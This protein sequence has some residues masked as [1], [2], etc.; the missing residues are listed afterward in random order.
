MLDAIWNDFLIIAREEVGSRV[1]ETWLKAVTLSSWDQATGT[2]FIEAP[3]VFVKDWIANNYKELFSTHLGRLVHYEQ[4]KIFFFTKTE[5]QPVFNSHVIPACSS[6][7]KNKLIPAKSASVSYNNAKSIQ[8]ASSLQSLKLNPQYTFETC[9]IG[10]HNSLAY[11]AAQ[12]VVDKPGKLYN[13]LYIYG[14]S[15]L[16][17]THLMHAIGNSLQTK[18]PNALIL[19]QTADRFVNEFIN[20]IRCNKFQ[21]FQQKYRQ[22]DV[23]LIDDIQFISQK[24]QTQEAFFHIFNALHE[25]G[26]Q[27]VFSSDVFP[28]MIKGLAERLRS[29]LEWGLVA[30][31]HAPELETK[32]AILHKKAAYHSVTIDNSIAE[33]IALSCNGNIRELE[34]ALIRILAFC[35]LTKTEITLEVAKKTLGNHHTV[36]ENTIHITCEQ[37]AQTV[38]KHYVYSLSDLRSER[39]EKDISLARQ[40]A[41]YL[42]KKLTD[43]SLREIGIFLR[44]KNHSTVIHALEKIEHTLSLDQSLKETL[45]FL[46]QKISSYS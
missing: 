2:I 24:E 44:R 27:V 11:A 21:L 26:K 13:P 46:E 5:K 17:K 30:D 10:S 3:N 1:V 40:I 22:L 39:R 20:A 35:S 14:N 19:Y 31:V 37:V 36:K 8:P 4:P 25:S 41:M 33:Y 29:R 38:C 18:N 45:T 7:N 43:K 15:G 34:G 32:I 12:A 16:G 42:M 23:L 6:E 28:R 9:V